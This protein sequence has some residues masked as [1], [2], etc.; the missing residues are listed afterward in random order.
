VVCVRFP[1]QK[2]KVTC[3]KIGTRSSAN[4]VSTTNY[5]VRGS[6][7]G[8]SV[9]LS[10]RHQDG[11]SETLTIHSD[12]IGTI[13]VGVLGAAI[14]SARRVGGNQTNPFSKDLDPSGIPYVAT[15][16]FALY[17][18]P[19]K[20][21]VVG[22]ALLFGQTKVGIGLPKAGLQ[23]LGTALLAASADSSRPQ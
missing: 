3:S 6:V 18:V 10:V 11:K 22:M 1:T 14:D 21:D 12:A 4:L 9:T 5:E 15:K 8:K 13:A 20:S 17:D 16:G 23:Q 2:L 7:D 19:D